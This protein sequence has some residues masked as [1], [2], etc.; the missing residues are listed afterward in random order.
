M[1]GYADTLGTCAAPSCDGSTA[2]IVDREQPNTAFPTFGD[3]AGGFEVFI[4][5]GYA[6][7]DIVAAED[8]EANNVIAPLLAF[9]ERNLASAP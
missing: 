4:S 2:R 1:L 3:A 9:I 6:H 7:V 8:D 5:E